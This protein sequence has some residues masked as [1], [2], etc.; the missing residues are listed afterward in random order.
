MVRGLRRERVLP[1]FGDLPDEHAVRLVYQILLGREPDPSGW[2]DFVGRL[3]R[4]ELTKDG[5][6]EEI[7]GSEEFRFH[8]RFTELARSVHM[9]RCD[10]VQSLPRAG[11][12]VDLG[13]TNLWSDEGALVHMGYPYDFEELVIVDL[14]PD[15]RH[16]IYRTGGN[17][18]AVVSPRGPVRYLY[19][20]M[21]DL[22]GIDDG[23]IDLVYSGQSIEHVSEK[24]ADAVL[25]EVNRVLRPGGWLAVDTPNARATRLQQPEFI[26][27]DHE[28]EYTHAELTAKLAT[29]GFEVVEAKGLNYL[30]RSLA[31]GAF[32]P[33]EAAGNTGL[34]AEIEDCYI[35]AYLCQKPGQV[36]V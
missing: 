23:T 4:G 22:A 32:D 31:A 25:E 9:S 18:D 20:S 6:V 16:P 2:N 14:P 7:R 19:Q 3:G 28:V 13:G 5:L 26:D 24:E 15:E 29:A 8:R 27:P 35:L 10:F 30:G 21:T 36:S 1:S 34:F 11:R 17:V 12:I 33:A